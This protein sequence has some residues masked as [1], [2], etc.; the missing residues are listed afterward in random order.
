MKKEKVNQ[1]VVAKARGI[2][3]SKVVFVI[4]GAYKKKTFKVISVNKKGYVSL[5]KLELLSSKKKS[6]FFKIHHSNLI[7]TS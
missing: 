7:L 1:S 3:Q 6:Y 4:S 5:E 2:K